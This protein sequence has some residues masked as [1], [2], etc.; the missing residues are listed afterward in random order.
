MKKAMSSSDSFGFFL[1]SMQRRSA[2][3]GAAKAEPLTI[4]RVLTSKG[5]LTMPELLAESHVRVFELT[6]SLKMMSEAGLVS[7]EGSGGEETV[8]LTPTG[9]KVAVLALGGK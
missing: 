1:E 7:L 4:L 5:A 9:A 8:E 6:E 2:G 3:E